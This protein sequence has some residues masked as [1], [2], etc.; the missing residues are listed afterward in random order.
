MTE[1]ARQ[2]YGHFRAIPG[3]GHR[4][5]L[6]RP[7]THDGRVTTTPLLPQPGHA[8]SRREHVSMSGYLYSDLQRFWPSRRGHA[9]DEFCR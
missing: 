3:A 7:G 6:R 5:V 4:L 9:F 1:A 8:G 2:T